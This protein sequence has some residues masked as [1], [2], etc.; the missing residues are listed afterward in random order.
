MKKI[1]PLLL[2]ALLTQ[3]VALAQ[4]SLKAE[5]IGFTFVSKNVDGTLGG[6]QSESTID[7]DD[8]NRS[9]INGSVAVETIKT[10]N[11]IR[12][13]SLKKSKYFDEDEHPRIYFK[14]TDVKITDNGFQAV[15]RITIKGITK[16]LNMNFEKKGNRLIA[17]AEL[18]SSDFDIFIK[19]EREENRVLI[20]LTFQLE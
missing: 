4:T 16:P 9:E 6:F 8:L 5:K 18:Y 13:W 20:E 7:L 1:L 3:F 12:D 14:S 2:I 15:G 11:F 17:K 10:G 19:D